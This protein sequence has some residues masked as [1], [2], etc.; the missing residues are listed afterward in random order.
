MGDSAAAAPLVPGDVRTPLSCIRS[1]K[2]YPSLVA[3]DLVVN[4]F[5]DMTCSGA[6]TDHFFEA[7]DDNP[8]QLSAVT[9]ATTLVTIGPIGANGLA[10]PRDFLTPV[11]AYED[12]EGA[13]EFFMKWEGRLYRA[14]I[15]QSPLDVIAWHGNY[16]PCKYDLN[17]YC[18]IGAVL[19]DHPDP[20]I[21]TVLPAYW[22]RGS[23][24]CCSV[25]LRPSKITCAM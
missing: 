10:N 5:Q 3:D 12:Y 14:D 15:G 21:F 16:A 22:P 20:S 7:Q 18:P 1:G 4:A 2:N 8:P 13:C 6:K 9:P 25:P 19:F 17:T 11:A 23:S 24:T